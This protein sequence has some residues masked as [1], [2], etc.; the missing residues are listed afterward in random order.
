MKKSLIALFLLIL[1]GCTHNQ[2]KHLNANKSAVNLYP[3]YMSNIQ[4]CDTLY[5]GRRTNQTQAAI[6]S[7]FN[8]RGLSRSWCQRETNKLYLVHAY[9]YLSKKLDSSSSDE[10]SAVVLPA[11]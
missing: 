6:G 2:A 9:E 3:Q 7:E 1:T 5:Y 4:L 11:N 10:A 8:R